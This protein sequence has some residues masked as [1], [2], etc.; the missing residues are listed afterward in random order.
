MRR[1]SSLKHAPAE[2][3]RILRDRFARYLPLQ[4]RTSNRTRKDVTLPDEI[5]LQLL[6]SLTIDF[7]SDIARAR[8]MYAAAI[9]P[10]SSEPSLDEL[11]ADGWFREVWGRISTPF[12]VVCAARSAPDGTM[13]AFHRWAGRL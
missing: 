9:P 6:L 1:F 5:L 2:T 12:E 8:V 3:R 10:N 4:H 11:A 13:T 7:E